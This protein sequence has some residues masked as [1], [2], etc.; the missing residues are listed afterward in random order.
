MSDGAGEV[1]SV[2]AGVTD[3]VEG[4]AVLSVFFPDWRD[5]DITHDLQKNVSGDTVDG[6]GSELFVVSQSAL[7]HQPTG[8]SHSEASTLPCAALTAWRA[9]VEEGRVK[10]GDWVL[11]QGT[12]GV[13]VFAL[14]FA[15]A[16]GARVIA[17][18]SSDAKASKM[19]ELGA[20]AVINYRDVSKWGIEAKKITGGRGVDQVVEIGGPATLNQS[21]RACRLGG[22]IT[23]I[24]VLTGMKGEVNTAEFFANNLSMTGISVGNHRM[25]KDMIAAIEARE[26]KPVIDREF[27][28]EDLAGAFKHQ[29]AQKHLGKVVVKGPE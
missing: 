2:G 25:Q 3:F 10:P 14:Q 28:F 13:S 6:V 16:A 4:D 11:V 21:I 8:D 27:A 12:G 26:I 9:V 23:M 29:A 18:S 7:T 24:G 1:V 15:K 22:H 5:G 19:M 17:T 20:D